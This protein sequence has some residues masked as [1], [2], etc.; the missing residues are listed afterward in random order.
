M[1]DALSLDGSDNRIRSGSG[2][3]LN[4]GIN[5]PIWDLVSCDCSCDCNQAASGP[6]LP[7][8]FC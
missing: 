3:Y 6:K 8:D 7:K 2:R 4:I 5:P 1:Y